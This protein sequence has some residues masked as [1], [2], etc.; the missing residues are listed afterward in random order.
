MIEILENGLYTRA[1][2]AE[3][4][5]PLGIDADTFIGRLKPRR[6]FRMAWLGKHIVEAFDTAPALAERGDTSG[7]AGLPAAQNR[8][9]RTRRGHARDTN[10][11]AALDRLRDELRSKA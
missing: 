1:D 6:V 9:N 11:M 7:S 10:G 8:G 4:L 2:L 5:G 3:L